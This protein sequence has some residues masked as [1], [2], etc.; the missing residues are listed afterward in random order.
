MALREDILQPV[1]GD[2]PSG[3]DL[4]YDKVYEDVK[5]ARQQDDELLTSGDWATTRKVADWKLVIKVSSEALA[6]KS[7]DL[8]LAAWLT[9]ALLNDQ[10]I[11]GLTDG[12]VLIKG[13]LENFW[14]TVYPELEDGE[15]EFRAGPL[16]WVGGHYL[17]LS[18]KKV[19]LTKNGLSVLKYTEAKSVGR[20]S[21][22]TDDYEKQA[23]FKAAVAEGKL[24]MDDWEKAFI[25]TPKT[26][27]VQLVA[28][29]DACLAGIDDLQPICEEKFG[30]FIP[31]FSKLR[32]AVTEQQ[33]QATQLLNEKR[34]TE[35]DEDAEPVEE[36]VN[37]ESPQDDGWGTG[38]GTAVQQ[39]KS[40]SVTSVEPIDKDDAVSRIA[41]AAAF[42]RREDPYSPAPYL[43]LRGLRWGEMRAGALDPFLFDA[44]DTATRTN[45]KRMSMEGDHAGVIELAET[46]M[47]T[48]AGRA[49]LDLQ[50]YVVR[51]LETY[52]YPAIAD[53]IKA[54]LKALLKDYP[55]ILTSTLL[56]DTPTA[57]AE[58][59][60]WITEF[61]SA[62]SQASTEWTA[63]SMDAAEPT[64]DGEEPA[65]DTF[66]LAMNAARSGRAQEAL[67]MLTVEIGRQNSGRGRFQ[68]KL[69]LAQVCLS[70]GHELIAHSILD[71][72]ASTVDR[73][74]LEN[75]EAPDVVAHALSLLYGCM[76]RNGSDPELGK[77]LYARIC[78]LDPVQALGH[79]R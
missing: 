18:V 20:E 43:L 12:L 16:D 30:Q 62:D 46:A 29:F 39:K 17:T 6:V 8:Q 13:L 61:S 36:A 14:D 11:N 54:E 64:A 67:E 78:R 55:G 65:P 74:Q 27:Y 7:K 38:S 48:P 76:Q 45:L 70:V 34:I 21:D 69:Q 68:R 40:R 9:E 41:A 59:L 1:P 23:E 51:A 28:N 15:A 60:A 71:E 56:D 24:T 44:P 73:H 37:E 10:G 19:G 31:S 53:A 47:A 4:R 75:W 32:E 33:R 3:K 49:W 79:S 66:Q 22:F 26:F 52:G 35:P 5:K 72:L 42:W 77:L 25:G 57:N 50:R 58:T 2:N 63:P